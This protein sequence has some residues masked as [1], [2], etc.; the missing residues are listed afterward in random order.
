MTAPEP[1][2][3]PLLFGHAAAEAALQVRRAYAERQRSEA[4]QG[5]ETRLFEATAAAAAERAETA[6]RV[7]ALGGSGRLDQPVS[8]RSP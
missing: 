7:A 3:N 2:A 5:G 4:V 6:Q 1:R 8:L